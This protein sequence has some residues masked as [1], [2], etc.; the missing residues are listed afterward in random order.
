MIVDQTADAEQEI[1]DAIRHYLEAGPGI[2]E[3]FLSDY[4]ETVKRIV[5]LPN[6]WPRVGK[7]LR[8]CLLSTFPYQIIY[9]IEGDSIRIYAVAHVK[10][11]PGYWNKR[12]AR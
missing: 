5:A 9:R 11:R 3:D 8:R 7:G 4:D 10:R 12:L 2:A 6:A 1:T